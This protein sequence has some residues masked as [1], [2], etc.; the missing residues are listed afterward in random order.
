MHNLADSTFPPNAHARL[1]PPP[2]DDVLAIPSVHVGAEFPSGQPPTHSLDSVAAVLAD[3][4]SDEFLAVL[5]HELRTPLAAL[6]HAVRVL[7]NPM[8][9]PGGRRKMQALIERQVHR[10]TQL[11]DDLL[12]VSRITT[13]RL[14]LRRARL[15]LR[16]VVDRAAETLEVQIRERRHRLTLTL[17]EH[18]VW[19]WADAERLEQV[20]VNLLANACRYTD[21]GGALN[22][23]MQTRERQVAVRVVDNGIGISRDA[24]P[25][26]F[27][28]FRQSSV[29]ERHSTCGLGIGLAVVRH[30][31]ELH[32]GRVTAR[33][34]G[35]GQGS[36]FTVRLPAEN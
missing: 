20:F 32:G 8:G 30:V 16:T 27:E 7:G 2:I 34:A 23:R 9:D 15:D 24:L 11:V 33:S 22:V 28:L 29:D 4:R 18:P 6:H 36:E 17:P 1:A 14:S 12:D 26:I 21:R 35:I 19:L 3:R 25:R 10:M 5:S 31:V 13:G